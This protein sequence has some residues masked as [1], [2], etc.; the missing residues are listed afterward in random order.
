MPIVIYTLSTAFPYWPDN[1][2]HPLQLLAREIAFRDPVDGSER[3]FTSPR[4]LALPA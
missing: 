2:D 4:S 3:R 1:F